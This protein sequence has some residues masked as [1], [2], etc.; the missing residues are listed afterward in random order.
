[1]FLTPW[2][3]SSN[4]AN[5]AA[6]DKRAPNGLGD[7]LAHQMVDGTSS[8]KYNPEQHHNGVREYPQCS[9]RVQKRSQEGSHTLARSSSPLGHE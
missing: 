6:C 5:D 3:S 8:Q 1:M 9:H 2:R 4:T 7:A